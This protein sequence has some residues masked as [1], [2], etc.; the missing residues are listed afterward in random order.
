MNKTIRIYTERFVNGVVIGEYQDF[1][2]KEYRKMLKS[3]QKQSK[4]HHKV[5][6]TQKK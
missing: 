1:T 5:V 2:E 3:C 4:N 6:K